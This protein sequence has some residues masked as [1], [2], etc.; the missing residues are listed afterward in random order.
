[1]NEHSELEGEPRS[2]LIHDKWEP[3]PDQPFRIPPVISLPHISSSSASS[4]RVAQPRTEGYKNIK[5]MSAAQSA[6][7]TPSY[8]TPYSNIEHVFEDPEHEHYYSDTPPPGSM[9][10]QTDHLLIYPRQ[11]V[12]PT[13]QAF[14]TLSKLKS[15]GYK[16]VWEPMDGDE[17]FWQIHSEPKIAIGQRA[18]LVKTPKG[19][20]LWDCITLLDEE[21]IEWINSLGGLAAIVIS[22]PHY[23]TTHLEWADAFDCPV[24]L[25]WEDKQWLNRLDR[26]G[27]A[28]TFI[29]GTEEDIEVRGEKIGVK[30]VK[31]GGHFP[32][33]LVCLAFGRLL[34]ADTLV[35]TPSGMGDWTKGPDGGKWGRPSG[36]NTYSFFWSI[37]NMIPLSAEEIAGMWKILKDYEFSSTHGAFKGT[38]VSD[39]AKGSDT[40]VKQRV[41]ESMQ[42]QVKRMGW[43]DHAFLQETM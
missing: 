26:L 34:I 12:L 25:S 23:Y 40:T 22:H 27:K 17:R 29:E 5:T 1:M 4:A 31:L 33:S 7:S 43:R 3:G 28:R 8:S 35:T 42:I 16:N 32:G 38:E 30:I 20:V 18:I 37:P 15:S 36:M 41:L 39:G 24:Y 13:G 2:R 19:N 6:A 14:T 10:S 9:A 21:T 11:F